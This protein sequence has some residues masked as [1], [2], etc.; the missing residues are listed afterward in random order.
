VHDLAG[1]VEARGAVR[2]VPQFDLQRRRIDARG[3]ADDHAQHPALGQRRRGGERTRLAVVQQQHARAILRAV[4]GGDADAGALQEAE[5]RRTLGHELAAPGELLV[6]AIEPQFARLAAAAAFARGDDRAR[7]RRPLHRHH[8]AR[9]RDV[10]L[11][12]APLQVGAQLGEPLQHLG[13]GGRRRRARPDHHRARHEAH[14][15]HRGALDRHEERRQRETTEG[16]QQHAVEPRRKCLSRLTHV[17]PSRTDPTHRHPP[18]QEPR[19]P[20][21]PRSSPPSRNC[22]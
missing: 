16:E 6:G 17:T 19:P 4:G 5:Q 2:I 22:E 11:L 8:R 1:P 3:W 12:D 15:A 20:P 14:R 10:V 18:R 13:L 9:A 7:D 21:Q